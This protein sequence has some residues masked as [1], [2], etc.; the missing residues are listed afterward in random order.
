MDPAF[1]LKP[2][3]LVAKWQHSGHVGRDSNLCQLQIKAIHEPLVFCKRLAEGPRRLQWSQTLRP[4][5]LKEQL[6]M[7]KVAEV[8]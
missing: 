7:A 1:D 6:Q 4:E 8:T 3:S 5:E 2:V